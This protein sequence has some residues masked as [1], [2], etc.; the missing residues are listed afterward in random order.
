M[1]EIC[2]SKLSVYLIICYKYIY[3]LSNSSLRHYK[4][5]SPLLYGIR[6]LRQTSKF[7]FFL[8]PYLLFFKHVNIILFPSKPYPTF[9]FQSRATVLESAL[10]IYLIKTAVVYNSF[11]LFNSD[12][13]SF[14]AALG[15]G[16]P[17]MCSCL[18]AWQC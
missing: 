18:F 13:F 17:L 8:H 10:I 2:I 15:H 6:V 11:K 4:P 14:M 5:Q 12:F 7:F 16:K 9:H 3:V 1:F